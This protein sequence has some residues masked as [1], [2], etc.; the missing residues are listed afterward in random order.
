MRSMKRFLP[1]LLTLAALLLPVMLTTH[2]CANTTQAPSGGDKDTIPPY[3]IDIKPLPGTTGVSVEGT[4]LEFTFNEYVS[5]KSA[6]NILLS[7][8]QKKMPKSKLKG[9]T[10]YVSFEEPLKPNTT[11]ALSFT[12]AIA[13]VNEGNMFA[14]YTYVFSTGEKI[15][16]MMITETVVNSSSLAPV[17]GA[18]VLLHKDH[19]DSAIFKSLPY[20]AAK[21]DDWGF[22]VMPFIQDTLYRLYAIKDENND[23][24]FDPESDMVAFIDSLIRPVMTASDTVREILRYDM[25]DTLACQERKS[26]Y[27][28][29]L[30]K[31][32]PSKQYVKDKVRTSERSAYISFL[33]PD[34]IID[35]LSIEGYRASQIISQFNLK[36]DSL[37]LWVNSRRNYPDT[38]KISLTYHKTDSLGQLRSTKENLKLPLPKD[39]RTFSKTSRK[40]ITRADTTCALTLT[41]DPKT[42]EQDGF[43]I[44]FRN[45]IIYEKFDSLQ[46]YSISPRQTEEKLSFTVERDSLNLRVYTIRP[47]KELRSGYEYHLK[48]PYRAFRDINGYYSDST[49]VKCSLPTDESLSTLTLE[50]SG[51]DQ[52]YIIDLM[53]EKRDKVLRSY[54]V[55]SDKSLVFPYLSKGKY[56]IRITSDENRNSLV[57]TGSVLEHRQSEK[58]LFLTFGDKKYLEIPEGSEVNQRVNL[59][60]L[61][62]K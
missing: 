28:L 8:P 43:T 58:L 6:A 57:D 9:K 35:T 14:G 53:G 49:E 22:F 55:D 33:A 36:R 31:E 59:K 27:E 39:K 26:E 3:I 18:T 30:F 17:K 10:L 44:E 45:P 52:K 32:T 46:F 7:P 50:L 15:D 19:S 24:L 12:D 54:V 37:E 41:A 11:Y 16:S 47:V 21:T 23:K 40:S 25:K 1:L 61:F 60:E 42:V 56:S 4:K 48:L 29:S 13:D 2:S 62:R 20:A 51:V 38:M 34:A 5:I